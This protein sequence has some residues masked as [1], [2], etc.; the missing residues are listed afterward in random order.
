MNHRDHP[1]FHLGVFGGSGSG[2]TTY[3]LRF[4]SRAVSSCV[5]CFD[6]DG[7]FALGLNVAPARTVY[8]LDAA[9]RSGWVCFD[10]H[11]M[12]AGNL[13]GALE[14]FA[15]LA[16]LAGAR[17]RGRKFFVVDELGW[18]VSGSNIGHWLRVLVQSGRRKAGIDGVFIAQ[19]PNEL[20]N[21]VRAQL[22]EVVC[23]QMTEDCALDYPRKFGFDVEAVRALQPF[24]FICR[25][26]RGQ[27]VRG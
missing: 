9:V 24:Q 17:L 22:N 25:N 6:P 15:H 23:Y 16:L 2:K 13:E 21:F 26:N 19:S 20:H 8:E 3:A 11:T 12:F 4:V 18:Y 1:R 5:F 27:E 7:D 10:P 14:Y